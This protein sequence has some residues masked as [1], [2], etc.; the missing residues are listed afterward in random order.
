MK[1]LFALAVLASIAHA[2]VFVDFALEKASN[3]GQQGQPIHSNTQWAFLDCG[4]SLALLWL[5]QQPDPVRTQEQ[6][7][8]PFKLNHSAS[9]LIHLNLVRN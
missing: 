7:Q 6:P 1:S 3:L 5:R 9:L 4:L 2:N 8:M